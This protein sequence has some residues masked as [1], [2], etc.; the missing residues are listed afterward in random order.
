MFIFIILVFFTRLFLFF[1]L[2]YFITSKPIAVTFFA[3]LIGSISLYLLSKFLISVCKSLNSFSEPSI[4]LEKYSLSAPDASGIELFPRV[5]IGVSLLFPSSLIPSFF[6]GGA[7]VRDI[8]DCWLVLLPGAT[9]V[10]SLRGSFPPPLTNFFL[11]F[12]VVLCFLPTLMFPLLML[13]LPL[14][15]L[16]FALFFVMRFLLLLLLL[17]VFCAFIIVYIH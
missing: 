3:I 13:S 11:V 12:L 15:F 2:T 16:L 17:R 5:P 10:S 6:K 8:L 14:L 9:A 4:N 1:D 7:L